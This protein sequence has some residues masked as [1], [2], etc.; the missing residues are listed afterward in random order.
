[1]ETV[2]R[3][4]LSNFTLTFV[5]IGLIA[6]LIALINA[7][8][9]LTAPVVVEALLSYFMLFSIGV[10]FF[11]NFVMHSF[12][13]EMAA[14]FIGW[15]DSPFQAEVGY[16]SL[17]FALIGFL[18]FRGSFDMRLA[19]VVGIAAFLWGAA[20]GHIREIIHEGNLAPGNAGV[21][22]YTDI[23]LPVAG[24]VL[25]WL[26]HRFGREVHDSGRASLA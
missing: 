11:Y 18:A 14:S 8:K 17:G 9:P 23:L 26:Q 21:I 15:A 6:S 7:P 13:G 20:G 3:F 2:I 12:F 24:F 10:S 25:L 1:M 16:A 4:A 22:L 19:A 5:I